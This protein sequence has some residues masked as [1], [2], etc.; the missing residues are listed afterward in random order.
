MTEANRTL[1][2]LLQRQDLGDFLCDF[3]RAVAYFMLQTLMVVMSRA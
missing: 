3:L 1:I 2:D